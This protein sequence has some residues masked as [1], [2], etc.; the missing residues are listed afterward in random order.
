MKSDI[1]IITDI[2]PSREKPIKGVDSKLII[3]ELLKLGHQEVYYIGDPLSLPT[4][5]KKMELR[6]H[7]ILVM[8]AGNIWRI[9]NNIYEEIK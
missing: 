6:D 1:V 9:C 5:I 7:I 8:G 2:Y 3:N 4:F